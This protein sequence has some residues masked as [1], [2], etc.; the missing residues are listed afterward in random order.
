M[1]PRFI[2][3][4]NEAMAGGA[5]ALVVAVWFLA[6][7]MVMAKAPSVSV[8]LPRAGHAMDQV[9]AALNR[10]GDAYAYR[11]NA[12]CRGLPAAA[13]ASLRQRLNSAA[14]IDGIALSTVSMNEGAR[15]GAVGAPVP[16]ALQLQASGPYN[17]M[18][19]FLGALSRLQPQIFLSTVELRSNTSTVA[20]TLNGRFY[21][22]ISARP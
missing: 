1:K 19:S 6:L 18:M 2:L 14:A 12:L 13:E 16:V 11:P 9:E 8:G 7:L 15:E 22:S 4:V 5:V 20:L 17:A 10:P 21:C 3:D